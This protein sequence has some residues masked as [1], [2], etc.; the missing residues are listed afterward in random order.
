M[1]KLFF[2]LVATLMVSSFSI[3]KTSEIKLETPKENTS[4][5]TENSELTVCYEVSRTERAIGQLGLT[6]VTITYRC[7]EVSGLG[8][9]TVYIDAK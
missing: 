6:E 1:K 7:T 5:K 2:S 8:N 3:A 9:G 4:K